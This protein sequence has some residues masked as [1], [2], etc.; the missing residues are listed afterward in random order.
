MLTTDTFC[1]LD[2]RFVVTKELAC[3][4]APSLTSTFDDLRPVFTQG[5]QSGC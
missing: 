5:F 3:G 4:Y 2:L 1:Y